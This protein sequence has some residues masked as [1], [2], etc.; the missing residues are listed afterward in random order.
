MPKDYKTLSLNSI[1]P[2]LGAEVS[3]VD[4]ATEFGADQIA[5]IRRAF[6]ENAVLVFRDQ[7]IS[8]D[9][10]KD[11]GRLFGALHIHPAKKTMGMKGDLEIFDVKA[12]E[13]TKFANGALWHA[14]VT[15]EEIPPLGS[16]LLMKQSPRV[17]GDTIFANMNLA[18]ETLSGPIRSMLRELTAVHDGLQDLANYGIRPSANIDYPRTEHPVVVRHPDTGKELLFVNSAFT[19]HIKGMSKR[20]SDSVLK[21]LYSHIAEDARLHCRVKWADDTLVF[22]DNRAVQHYAV[23]DYYPGIRIAERVS[24]QDTVRPTA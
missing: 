17:G 5:E 20:E 11:F 14:D 18:F 23:F 6:A 22:W 1:T 7:R 24:I 21:L 8:R 19:S 15:C 12:D 9:R 3:G 4:L 10:H 2:H 16:M 13:N